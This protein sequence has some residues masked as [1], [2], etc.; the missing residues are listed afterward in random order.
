MLGKGGV[1]DMPPDPHRLFV[2]YTT[3]HSY[4][5]DNWLHIVPGPINSLSRPACKKFRNSYPIQLAGWV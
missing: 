5:Y 3:K 4:A 2:L 1:E